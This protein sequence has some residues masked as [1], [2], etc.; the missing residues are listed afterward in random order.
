M[1]G[2]SV[3]TIASLPCLRRARRALGP[4]LGR[5]TARRVGVADAGVAEDDPP[6]G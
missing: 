3:T 5:A 1:K 2:S 6:G 4:A